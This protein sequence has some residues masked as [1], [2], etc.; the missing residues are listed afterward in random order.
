MF[1]L[2]PGSFKVDRIL[3]KWR[4]FLTETGLSRVHQHM[5]NHD[6]AVLTSFR[7]DITDSSKCTEKSVAYQEG[8]TN[9]SRNRDLKA[10]LLSQNYGV[11]KG[12]GSYIENYDTPEAYEVSEDSFFVVNLPDDAGF[13]DNLITLAEKYCQDSVLI[14]PRGGDGAYLRGTNNSE[15]PGFG[16]EIKVGKREYGKE[17]EFMTKIRNRPFTFGEELETYKKL[18]K[19]ERMAVRAISKK[20]LKNS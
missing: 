4:A 14:I 20:I 10:V 15:F 17:K 9:L 5:E 19:N 3:N 16:Q 12:K 13:V 8:E 6:C 11:T 18:S 2:L 7:A 1:M